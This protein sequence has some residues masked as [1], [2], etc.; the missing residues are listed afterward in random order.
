MVAALVEMVVWIFLYSTAFDYCLYEG[1]C[2]ANQWTANVE[3]TS[4]L[5]VGI[6]W[7]LDCPFQKPYTSWARGDRI[8]PAI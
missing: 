3:L 8:N 7:R 4:T 5:S 1:L 6:R 2:V